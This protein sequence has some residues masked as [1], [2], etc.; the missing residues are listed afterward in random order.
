M[1]K[2]TE[3]FTHHSGS[4]SI[5]WVYEIPNFYVN[6]KYECYKIKSLHLNGA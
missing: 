4:M 2:F 3:E 5:I 6:G 1:A